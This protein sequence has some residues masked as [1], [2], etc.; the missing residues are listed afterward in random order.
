[1]A[2]TCIVPLSA[3]VART[4]W[5][6]A[7]RSPSN[8]ADATEIGERPRCLT[9]R[10]SPS[11][12]SRAIQRQTSTHE[13]SLIS[14]PLQDD[15]RKEHNDIPGFA[16]THENRTHLD[17]PADGAATTSPAPGHRR[18]PERVANARSPS[19]APG[20]R[21]GCARRRFRETGTREDRSTCWTAATKENR[22]R[23]RPVGSTAAK[24]P[25]LSAGLISARRPRTWKCRSDE[26]STRIDG[27]G[28]RPHQCSLPASRR[29]KATAT[30]AR[31]RSTNKRHTRLRRPAMSTTSEKST[32]PGQLRRQSRRRSKRPA[33][34]SDL[35]NFRTRR[36]MTVLT[37]SCRL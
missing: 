20:P 22:Y 21:Q 31:D 17:F 27:A 13:R 30:V 11:S 32:G 15:W 7:E 37:S 5:V 23:P 33:V 34:V 10:Y 28:L 16:E 26:R 2:R 35:A 14:G 29:Q 36:P 9:N 6:I 18:R 3:N 8:S 19:T 12:C 24:R 1:M 4:S 25:G